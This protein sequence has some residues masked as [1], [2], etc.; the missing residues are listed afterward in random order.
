MT[1]EK[2]TNGQNIPE[3]TRTVLLPLFSYIEE[4]ISPLEEYITSSE[5]AGP[6]SFTEWMGPTNDVR[7]R[8][9][10][11]RGI[12]EQLAQGQYNGIRRE[13][14]ADIAKTAT[15][16]A[17]L[18]ERLKQPMLGDSYFYKLEEKIASGRHVLGN[19]TS[20]EDR[21]WVS[22]VIEEYKGEQSL[23][24]RGGYSVRLSYASEKLKNLHRLQRL[25]PQPP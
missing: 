21:A 10:H 19:L 9:R 8:V 13:L 23:T 6:E 14:Q 12:G 5:N 3:Y 16:A 11:L 18:T 17:Q 7:A 2:S 4:Q 20:G 15:E 22:D 1:P 25:I 24:K